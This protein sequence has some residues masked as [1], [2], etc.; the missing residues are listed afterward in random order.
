[1]HVRTITEYVLAVALIAPAA[2]QSDP[3]ATHAGPDYAAMV[4]AKD[5]I[6][7]IGSGSV[8]V[9]DDTMSSK[10]GAVDS[11]AARAKFLTCSTL[12]FSSNGQVTAIS[13]NH[14][15]DP[16]LNDAPSFVCRTY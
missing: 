3:G 12:T 9:V 5:E 10:R 15:A 1:M 6:I 16:F 11:V 8:D 2:G 7:R 14:F 13:S 4:A